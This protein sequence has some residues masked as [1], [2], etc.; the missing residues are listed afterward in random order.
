MQHHNLDH[1]LPHVEPISKREL[2]RHMA[3]L[4]QLDENKGIAVLKIKSSWLK[5][6]TTSLHLQLQKAL[7]IAYGR[8]FRLLM[9][10]DKK[11]STL[12]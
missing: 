8:E 2:V 9:Y 12:W 10:S 6:F 11:R 7:G 1:V 5:Y 4:T 3:L